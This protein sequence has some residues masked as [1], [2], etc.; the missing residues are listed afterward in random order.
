MIRLSGIASISCNGT[1]AIALCPEFQ[2]LFG[3]HAR[4]HFYQRPGYR[5]CWQQYMFHGIT[6]NLQGPKLTITSPAPL[7]LFTNNS[8]TVTGTVDDPQ[9]Q[10]SQ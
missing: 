8:T 4:C 5:H 10:L 6:V 9:C 2:L 1:P 3:D 7:S